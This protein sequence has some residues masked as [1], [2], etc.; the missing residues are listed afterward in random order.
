M[1]CTRK[2]VLS[3]GPGVVYYEGLYRYLYYKACVVYYKACGVC[4]KGMCVLPNET[5]SFSTGRRYAKVFPLPVCDFIR[6]FCGSIIKG[7]I[8]LVVEGGG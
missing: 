3:L 6:M 5:R 2:D 1:L 4:Y 7:T 8:T